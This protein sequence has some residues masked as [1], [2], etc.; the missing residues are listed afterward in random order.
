M[1]TENGYRCF[2]IP[3]DIGGRFSVFTAVGL[4]PIAASELDV[5]AVLKGCQKAREDLSNP[6]LNS[7]ISY[8]YA[9][10]RHILQKQGKDSEKSRR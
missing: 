2:V 3:D 7:N 4:L 1:A 5:K 8:Q 6:D 10:I 9:V